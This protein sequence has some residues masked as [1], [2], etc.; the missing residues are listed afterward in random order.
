MTDQNGKHK[1]YLLKQTSMRGLE[2][3]NQSSV[4]YDERLKRH[5]HV[6]VSLCRLHV[7]EKSVT[8]SAMLSTGAPRGA[9]AGGLAK[10]KAW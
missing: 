5:S 1:K 10:L 4:C 3:S 6:N 8:F 9:A 2:A 7:A